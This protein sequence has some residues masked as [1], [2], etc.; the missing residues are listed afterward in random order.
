[1]DLTKVDFIDSTIVHELIRAYNG[2]DRRL[3]LEVA[4]SQS[5]RRVL[6]VT[7]LMGFITTVDNREEAIA[8]ALAA[9]GDR[10]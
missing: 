8:L 2:C 7:G 4:T 9:A 10:R 3:V 1:V 5:V 6:E